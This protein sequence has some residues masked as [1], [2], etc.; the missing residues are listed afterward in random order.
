MSFMKDK[1]AIVAIMLASACWA[2]SGNAQFPTSVWPDDLDGRNG[3]HVLGDRTLELGR[4][5]VGIG[6]VNADGIDDIASG[7]PG[8]TYPPADC[9]GF[10]LEC[11]DCDATPGAVHVLFGRPGI[12]GD[13]SWSLDTPETHVLRIEGLNP[14]DE[15]DTVAP[16]GDF[17]NDGIDD[18]LVGAHLASPGGIVLAGAAYLMYGGPGLSDTDSFDLNALDGSNGFMIAG[19]S[20]W[21]LIGRRLASIGDFNN[22]GVDDIAVSAIG[23]GPPGRPDAGQIYILFGGRGVGES[24][25]IVLPDSLGP[26]QGITLNGISAGD[27]AGAAVGSAGDFNGDGIND[28][29]VAAVYPEPRPLSQGQSYVVYGGLDAGHDGVFELADLDGTNGFIINGPAAPPGSA[30]RIK[31]GVPAG[32]GDINADGYDDIGVGVDTDSNWVGI[33]FGGPNVARNG[34]FLLEDLNGKNGFV[35]YR[36]GVS[37]SASCGRAG[38]LNRDGID[39]MLAQAGFTAVVF[40]KPGIGASGMMDVN[41][42]DGR[43]GFTWPGGWNRS[44]AGD[45]N[46]DGIDDV[47][48]GSPSFTIPCDVGFMLVVFGRRMGDGDLDADVDLADF[49]GFQACYGVPPDGDVPDACH[50]FDFDKDNDVDLADFEA[51]QKV[52]GSGV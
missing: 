46:A 26:K 23:D 35:F 40:G 48:S 24:G 13:G 52:F 2:P 8:V 19:G 45:V 25:L 6:D 44:L 20:T 11:P 39:D 36:S 33:V 9:G 42:L 3:F 47:V 49:G 29:V 15:T 28:L 1:N 22:D 7:G 16:A 37:S 41:D 21:A 18:F 27:L 34:V 38:D 50:P 31:L 17:N 10:P 4:S 43:E 51:F 5:A 12:G 30:G 14:N 32:V